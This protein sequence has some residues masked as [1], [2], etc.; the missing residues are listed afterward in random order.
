MIL[1]TGWDWHTGVRM[2]A[3]VVFVLALAGALVWGSSK[4]KK[5]GLAAFSAIVGAIALLIAFPELLSFGG[6]MDD[7][8]LLVV[9]LVGLVLILAAFASAKTPTGLLLLLGA[10]TV[11]WAVFRWLPTGPAAFEFLG[12]HVT[13]AGK[14]LWDGI[15]GFGEILFK[16]EPIDGN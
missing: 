16:S 14:E 5:V 7:I 12:E 10:I 3:L 9:G 2:G 13:A 4:N 1:A 15:V 6:P 8:V 11:A